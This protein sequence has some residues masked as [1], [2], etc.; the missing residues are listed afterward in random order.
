MNTL[1]VVVFFLGS[2]VSLWG[3]DCCLS[4]GARSINSLQAMQRIDLGLATSFQDYSSWYNFSLQASTTA[5][6]N[7]NLEMFGRLPLIQHRVDLKTKRDSQT[8]LGDVGLGLRMTLLRSLFV[9]DPHP[10]V[11]WVVGAKLPTGTQDLQVGNLFQS[12]SGNGLFEPL[13]GLSFSKEYYDWLVAIDFSYTRL[14]GK[15]S[16]LLVED[17]QVNVTET[18]SYALNRNWQMGAGS[19]QLWSFGRKL[20]RS[21]LADPTGKSLSVF[22]LL[23]YYVTP[24][25]SLGAHV[26]WAFETL[27][28]NQPATRSAS[29]SVRYGFY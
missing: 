28:R 15:I 7:P 3:T 20:N 19:N 10:T 29:L 23:N 8:S 22:G 2:A 25:T 17:N 21:A 26:D 18:L 24:F 14:Q 5:R 1:R 4:G 6:L 12:R 16:N 9:E 13:V 11:S 27:S